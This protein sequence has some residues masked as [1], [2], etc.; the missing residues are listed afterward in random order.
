MQFLS[1]WFLLGA[2]AV[3][4][5]IWLHLIRR[6][7]A[8]RIPFSSLMFFRRIPT[9]SLSRQRLK[10]LL[11]L[12]LRVLVILLIALAFA[13]PYLPGASRLL[14]TAGQGKHV[15]ILLDNSMSMQ[16]GDRWTKAL[17]AAR[18]VI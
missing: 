7:Q 17:E 3:A 11:L 4:V 9:K 14:T 18:K 1:P 2:L 10:Y 8:M 13:R 16:Y 15:A 12:S 6:Q 5:P